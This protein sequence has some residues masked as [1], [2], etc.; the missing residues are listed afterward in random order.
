M[1]EEVEEEVEEEAPVEEVEVAE[2]PAAG[3]DYRSMVCNRRLTAADLQG[4]SKKELRLMRNTIYAVHGRKFRSADLD[5]YFRQ[6]SWYKPVGYDIPA[7]SLSAT[8]M[9]NA[10][11]IAKYEK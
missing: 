1:E 4:K 8:E 11:L 5:K 9:A 10:A 6:F 2:A 3:S 7:K